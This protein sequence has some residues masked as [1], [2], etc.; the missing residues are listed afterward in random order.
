[1]T[2]EYIAGFFDGEGSLIKH[3][4]K[5]FRVVI[6]QTNLEVLEEIKNFTGVGKVI[7]VARR[8]DHWKRAWVYFIATQKDIAF[9]LEKIEKFVIVKKKKVDE[10]RPIISV[11]SSNIFLKKA[12]LDGLVAE[13]KRLRKK[14]MT[15]REI[16]AVLKKDFGQVRRMVLK[17]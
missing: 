1:M 4:G 10:A 3:K 9:F 7:E 14:G 6:S 13:A 11:V 12:S 17:K 5:Y 16:G 8:K 2:W 15:Y